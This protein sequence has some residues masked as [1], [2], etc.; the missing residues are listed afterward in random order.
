MNISISKSNLLAAIIGLA[1]IVTVLFAGMY[2]CGYWEKSRLYQEEGY[3]GHGYHSLAE[4]LARGFFWEADMVPSPNPHYHGNI[5][6]G[7]YVMG[8]WWI[9]LL[10][11]PIFLGIIYLGWLIAGGRERIS[12]ILPGSKKDS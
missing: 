8:L 9:S 2:P 4:V 7:Y 1:L 3:A 5:S 10:Y 6:A 12:V 11:I